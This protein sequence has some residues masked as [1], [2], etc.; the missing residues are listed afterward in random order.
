M[1]ASMEESSVETRN[2]HTHLGWILRSYFKVIASH[3][4]S[5]APLQILEY[6]LRNCLV[7]QHRFISD[8]LLHENV[9]RLEIL[10]CP[11]SFR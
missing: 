9:P 6:Q 3:Q 7:K 4:G 10:D 5:S 2:G 1:A 8:Y 11:R